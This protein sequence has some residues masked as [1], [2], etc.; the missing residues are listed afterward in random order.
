MNDKNKQFDLSFF[1]KR[2]PLKLIP[3]QAA[4][5]PIPIFQ[6]FKTLENFLVN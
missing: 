5:T 4:L 6:R 3:N 1:S 2:K